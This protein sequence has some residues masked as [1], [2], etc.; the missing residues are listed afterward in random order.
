MST[1]FMDPVVLWREPASASLRRVLTRVFFMALWLALAG[2]PGVFDGFVPW[3][4]LRVVLWVFAALALLHILLAVA[5]LVRN[6]G[7]TLRL[8]GTGS[9]EW[10][11]SLQEKL[12][13][14]RL[15]WVEGPIVTVT[16]ELRVPGPASSYPRVKLQGGGRSISRFPLHGTSIEDFVA[17]VNQAAAGRGIRFEIAQPGEEPPAE[18]LPA[19]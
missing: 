17:H 9:I 2:L 16:E 13:G 7:V 18:A 4:W 19:Q 14:A 8:M 6:R 3:T 1:A 12:L 11:Q 5:N 15:D 10:P